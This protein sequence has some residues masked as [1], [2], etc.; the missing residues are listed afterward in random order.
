MYD[1]APNRKESMDYLKDKVLRKKK[2]ISKN[3]VL[4]YSLGIDIQL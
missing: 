2:A 3:S 1:N 4:N